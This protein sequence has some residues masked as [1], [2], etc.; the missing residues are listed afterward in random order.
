ML[1]RARAHIHKY[2]K[3]LL[4]RFSWAFELV[5]VI[6]PSI[7]VFTVLAD[8]VLFFLSLMLPL[9]AGLILAAVCSHQLLYQLQSRFAQALQCSYPRRIPFLSAQRTFLTLLTVVAILAVDFPAFP[10]RLAKVE[11]YGVGL[12]DVG[13]GLFVYAHG[14]TSLEARGG[15]SSVL[16]VRLNLAAYFALVGKTA[17]GVF[18]LLVLGLLRLLVV[19]GSG[20]QE[21]ISEYGLH[22]NFFFSIASVRVSVQ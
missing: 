10:R 18:P 1:Q 14:V 19:K 22:W 6:L 20:Y 7:L 17:R 13:V 3:Y 4:R 2:T 21:H 9:A 5:I 12:M 15:G 8:H 11:T 16:K